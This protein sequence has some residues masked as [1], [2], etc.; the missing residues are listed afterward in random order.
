MVENKPTN[1]TI[2]LRLESGDVAKFFIP[3]PL[4]NELSRVSRVL[5][6]IFNQLDSL[7]LNVVIA[8]WDRIVDEALST[9]KPE[10][11]EK[12]KN[13]VYRFLDRCVAGG[14]CDIKD[15]N[16]L[17]E[18]DTSDL[19]GVLLFISAL[20]RYVWKRTPVGSNELAAFFTTLTLQEWKQSLRK[21][22]EA[23]VVAETPKEISIVQ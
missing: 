23:S 2:D 16:T 4:E 12:V 17:G 5:S 8:D 11:A 14:Y 9:L 20:Y 22:P 6:Y 18:M 7:S 15:I 13:D 10:Y 19:K 1:F 3:Q 21:Q